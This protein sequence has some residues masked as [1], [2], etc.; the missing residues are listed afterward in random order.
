MPLLTPTT[1]YTYYSNNTFNE[2]LLSKQQYLYECTITYDTRKIWDTASLWEEGLDLS[3][4]KVADWLY[5][6][7]N[8]HSCFNVKQIAVV[9]EYQKN[10]N[11]H[12]HMRIASKVKIGAEKRSAIVQGL[13]RL[14]GRSTF[15]PVRDDDLFRAYIMKDLES[16]YQKHKVS[17][18]CILNSKI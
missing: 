14:F 16:N 6:L 5:F 10:K 3:I 11:P 9:I 2:D 15:M 17:H 8:K 12:L 4:E 13:F 7:D 18:W 1:S